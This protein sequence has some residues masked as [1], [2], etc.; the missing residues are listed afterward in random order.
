MKTVLVAGASG[1]VGQAAVSHFLARGD[2]VIALSRRAP[3]GADGARFVAA[4]LVD[5]DA[6]RAAIAPL[7]DV[8]H[9]V[10]AAL[11]EKPRVIEG[12]FEDDQIDTNDRMFRNLFDPLVENA[13]GLRHVTLLQGTKAYGIR[14]PT[15][16]AAREDADEAHQEPNFY[17]RQEGHLRALQRGARWTFTILRPQII[18]GFALG[19]NLNAIPALAAYG[20]ILKE[21]GEPLHFPGAADGAVQE[22]VDADLLARAIGWAGERPPANEI[23]NVTNG[24][25]YAWPRIWPH[26]ASALGMS[27]GEHRPASLEAAAAGWSAEWDALRARHR[28]V[29]PGLGAFV[30][31]SFQFTDMIL[32]QI[33]GAPGAPNPPSLVSTVKLRQAGFHETMHTSDMFRAQIR[34]LQEMRLVPKP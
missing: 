28:L 2:R 1:L 13:K 3:Y 33:L 34:R 4:D 14:R 5:R 7:A 9:L 15:P 25:V 29:S 24:D 21:R 6:A 22:G 26:V 18:Y 10:Y 20:A 30:G 12:W 32:K 27:V 17:W 8:T 23:F 16:I 31:R 11:F 19:G